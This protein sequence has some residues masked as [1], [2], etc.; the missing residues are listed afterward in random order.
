MLVRVYTCQKVKLL[1]ISC[2]GSYDI[3]ASGRRSVCHD[4]W[5]LSRLCF[6]NSITK[7]AYFH[8]FLRGALNIARTDNNICIFY[9]HL[10][11]YTPLRL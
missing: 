3:R 8:V 11:T 6:R 2:R 1:E 7:A 4:M 5:Q 9:Q 10:H